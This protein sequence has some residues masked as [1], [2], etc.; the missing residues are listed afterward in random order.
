MRYQTD[1]TARDMICEMLAT[2]SE[3][4]LRAVDISKRMGKPSHWALYYLMEL[5][6]DGLA[7]CAGHTSQCRWIDAPRRDA[8]A[9]LLRERMINR[10]RAE[11]RCSRE[12]AI[13]L[14]EKRKSRTE[15]DVERARMSKAFEETDEP[16]RKHAPA[17]QWKAEVRAVRWVFDLGQA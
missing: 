5:R 15:R 1:T 17:G 8:L 11:R 4:G 12:R 16:I 14:V 2:A 10:L 13:K 9:N 3:D 7:G 6:K